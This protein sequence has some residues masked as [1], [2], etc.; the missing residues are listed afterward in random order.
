WRNLNLYYPDLPVKIKLHGA[1]SQTQGSADLSVAEG[2]YGYGTTAYLDLINDPEIDLIDICTPND[3]HFEIFTAALDAGKHIYIEKPLALNLDQAL[4]MHKLAKSAQGVIQ[5]AFNFR[6]IPAVMK[7][8]QLI[9][10]GFLGDVI[11]FRAQYFHTGYLNTDKPMSWRLYEEQSG[12]GALVDLGSHAIDLMLYLAGPFQR[13]MANT[14]TYVG[15]RPISPGAEIKAQ[16]LVDDHAQL[17]IEL[18][19]GGVGIVEVSRVAHGTTDDLN[20]EIH[21]TRGAMKF[22]VMNP[23]WLYFY[24]AGDPKKPIGGSHGYKQIQTIHEYPGNKI[25]G[26]RSLVNAMGMHANSQVQVVR[27][28]L[29]LQAPSPSVRDGLAV[30]QVLDASYRSAREECWVEIFVPED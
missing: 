19:G 8:K 14:K 12:G 22:D 29:G 15:Q 3:S 28:A 18:P 23:N 20:F 26:S 24:D 30:Q 7:A 10:D 2:G 13:I 1:A 9:D 27:A 16:V 21:G 5:I 17:L 25:P 6:F 4:E 11:N